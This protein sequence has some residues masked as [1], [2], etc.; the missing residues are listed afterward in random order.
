MKIMREHIDFCLRSEEKIKLAIRLKRLD[1]D[2]P[3]GGGHSS[4]IKRPTEIKALRN[5]MPVGTVLVDDF[6]SVENADEV[7]NLIERV[8]AHFNNL[9]QGKVYSMHY[10]KGENDYKVICNALGFKSPQTYYNH[11]N[12][13]LDYAEKLWGEEFG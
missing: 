1:R 12:F 13:I 5:L 2:N 4:G 10:I 8:K 11:L 7:V 6:Y 9:P 3:S